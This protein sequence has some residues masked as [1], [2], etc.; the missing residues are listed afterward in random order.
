MPRIIKGGKEVLVKIPRGFLDLLRVGY[1]YIWMLQMGQML[2]ARS[3]SS[4]CGTPP[5]SIYT[6][7]CMQ[8]YFL[9]SILYF[10]RDNDTGLGQQ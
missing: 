4:R 2:A 9:T 8:Y 5:P 1:I 3:P 6:Y 10:T 7:V